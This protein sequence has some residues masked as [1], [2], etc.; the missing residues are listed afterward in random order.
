MDGKN[1]L[2]TLRT[3]VDFA[4]K[5]KGLLVTECEVGDVIELTTLQSTYTIKLL[6]P[7]Q[8]LVSVK[9]SGKHFLDWTRTF[10]NGSS[11]TGTGSM[12]RL[13]WIGVGFSLWLGNV[14][15]TEVQSIRV[16]GEVFQVLHDNRD[17]E[18]YN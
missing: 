3:A 16:N 14:L 6:D 7:A 17:P 10:V 12:V 5:Q 13:G 1:G 9:G 8:K 11:M 15:I 4:A 2:V 18:T